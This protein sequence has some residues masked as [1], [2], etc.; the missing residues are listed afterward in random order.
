MAENWNVPDKNDI[1]HVPDHLDPLINYVTTQI[2]LHNISERSEAQIVCNIVA[3]CQQFFIS[4]P[5]LRPKE[6]PGKLAFALKHID[7]LEVH[8]KYPDRLWKNIKKFPEVNDI[9]KAARAELGYSP[10]TADQDII[11]TLYSCLRKNNEIHF[12]FPFE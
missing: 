3:K 1:I 10:R 12:T 4:N 2:R 8:K 7:F 5:P 11:H 9:I 6:R